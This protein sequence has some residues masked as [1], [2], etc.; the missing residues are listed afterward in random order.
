LGI[1]A[2]PIWIPQG[3]MVAGLGL[4]TLAFLDTLVESLRARRPARR[5]VLTDSATE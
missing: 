2:I 3:A 1:V 5:P 4:L